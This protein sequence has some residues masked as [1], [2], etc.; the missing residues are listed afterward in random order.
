MSTE[1][2]RVHLI[3]FKDGSYKKISE[4]KSWNQSVWLHYVKPNGNIVRVNL[5]NVN[6]IEEMDE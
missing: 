6:Y 4:P 5:N 1:A 3:S 2:K